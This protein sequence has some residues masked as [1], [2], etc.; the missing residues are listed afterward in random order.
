[1]KAVK[2][3]RLEFGKGLPKIGV[4]ILGKDRKTIEKNAKELVGKPYD[5]AEWRVD[6]LPEKGWNIKNLLEI[7]QSLREILLAK[8]LLFTIR[9]KN[10]GGNANINVALYEKLLLKVIESKA[11]PMVDVEFFMEGLNVK[12]IVSAA[13]K[14]G[15][16]IIASYHDFNSTP[17][18]GVLIEKMCFMQK[19]G[20]DIVKIAVMPQSFKDV[21]TVMDA[22]WQMHQNYAKVPIAVISMGDIG[23]LSRVSGEYTGSCLTFAALEEVSAPGQFEVYKM[24]RLLHNLHK[25]EDKKKKNHIFLIGFMGV[26]KST[27]ARKIGRKY[28]LRQ[29]DLDREIER[30]ENK[31]IA[32]IFA[33]EGETYFRKLETDYIRKLKTMETSIVSCGGGAVLNPENIRLMK[34][35]G[36]IVLLTGNPVTIYHRVKHNPNRPLLNG[37]MNIPYIAKLMEERRPAYEKAADFV[38]RTDGKRADEIC[39]EIWLCMESVWSGEETL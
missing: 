2:V 29:I 30:E 32:E 7:I 3:E 39:K 11:V 13:K 5:F 24:N 26:G 6:D 27:I 18:K 31:K 25:V 22:T 1:M 34:N 23:A 37:N 33:N 14:A 21:I 19:R 10:E 36:K 16:I 15:V 35:C 12:R 8:P 28:G 20:A 17:H 38:V 4:S 9:T